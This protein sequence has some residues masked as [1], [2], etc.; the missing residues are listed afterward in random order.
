MTTIN[1]RARLAAN[2][3]NS[4]EV[5]IHM[6]GSTASQQPKIVLRFGS[7]VTVE[8]RQGQIVK[9]IN[10]AADILEQMQEDREIR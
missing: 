3:W 2:K 1:A 8:M 9:L 5:N 6:I 10:Q 7:L 4:V